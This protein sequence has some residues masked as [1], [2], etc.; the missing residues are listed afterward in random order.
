M[1]TELIELQARAKIRYGLSASE[2]RALTPR[3]LTAYE[4]EWYD[5]EQLREERIAMLAWIYACA[6]SKKGRKPKIEDFMRFRQRTKREKSPE[7]LEALIR[8]IPGKSNG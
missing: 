3:E 1:E 8:M 6:H 5:L 2:F 7:E 4:K